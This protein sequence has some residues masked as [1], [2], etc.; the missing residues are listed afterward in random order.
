MPFHDGADFL[1]ALWQGRGSN[2][3]NLAAKQRH[4]S[5][6]LRCGMRGRQY[7][8]HL[9]GRFPKEQRQ[10]VAAL[11]GDERMQFVEHDALE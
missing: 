7:R 6:E 8:R 4:P 1:A 3:Q 10:E 9:L 2:S 11:G 5:S